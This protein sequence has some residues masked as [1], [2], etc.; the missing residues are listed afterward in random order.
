M[1]E[2]ARRSSICLHSLC[3]PKIW[4]SVL[5]SFGENYCVHL[6]IFNVLRM[7]L[8]SMGGPS[9]DLFCLFLIYVGACQQHQSFNIKLEEVSLHSKSDSHIRLGRALGISR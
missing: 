5:H 7:S 3:M 8:P 9:V 4:R 1:E 6:S 2:T